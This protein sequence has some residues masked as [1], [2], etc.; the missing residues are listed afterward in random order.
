MFSSFLDSTSVLEVFTLVKLATYVSHLKNEILIT[1]PSSQIVTAAPLALPP[2]VTKFL[3]AACMIE[4]VDVE[5]GWLLVK[6]IVWQEREGIFGEKE[7]TDAFRV[8]GT[9]HGFP[10]WPPNH[11]CTNPKCTRT[12]KGHKLQT[13]IA[14]HGI[15][16]TVGQGPVP[17]YVIHLEC[18]GRNGGTR[19]YYNMAQPFLQI[20]DLKYAEV[21]LVQSWKINTNIAWVSSSNNPSTYMAWYPNC[22]ETLPGEW[23]FKASTLDGDDVFLGFMILSLLQ[24]CRRRN[25]TLAVPHSGPQSHRFNNAIHGRNDRIRM[26]G[27]PLREHACTK[28][29]R[30]YKDGNG[31]DREVSAVVMDGIMLGH[32]TCGDPRCK[33]PLASTK[34]RFCPEHRSLEEKCSVVGCTATVGQGYRTCNDKEH[35]KI[36][37]VHNA[38]SSA[39][40]QLKDRLERAR[41][42]HPKSGDA[43]DTNTSELIGQDDPLEE[44]YA[45]FDNKIVP[46]SPNLLTQAEAAH[47]LILP[48]VLAP[49]TASSITAPLTPSNPALPRKKIRANFGQKQTHNEQILVTPCG[50][51]IAQDTFYNTESIPSVVDMIKRTY[52]NQCKPNHIVFDNNCSIKKHVQDDTW[53]ENVGLAVDV[54]HYRCK[55]SLTDMFCQ[56]NCNPADFPELKGEGGRGWYFNTSIAEQTNVWLGGFH[57][58]CRE[59]TAERYGLQGTQSPRKRRKVL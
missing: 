56:A 30:I 46:S 57:S 45:V 38:R 10:L 28:C 23:K 31:D 41:V 50:V 12:D 51:I 13:A 55:Q 20:T 8:F 6:D 11:M 24:D 33:L 5:S 58:I 25:T 15:L 48:L 1:H 17:A 22:D 35:R 49:T 43:I 4:E 34:A 59:M 14:R 9:K 44:T 26:Y 18:S 7:T 42:A 39:A 54:F 29:V 53:F 19:T 32:P 3:A 36:E 16:Y 47:Q 27:Q 21:P 37:E 40:F 52:L 2:S